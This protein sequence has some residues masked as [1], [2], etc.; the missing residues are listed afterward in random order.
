MPT[1]WVGK[2]SQTVFAVCAMHYTHVLIGWNHFCDVGKLACH[3]AK[4][5]KIKG[6]LPS[7][8]IKLK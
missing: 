3:N 6:G 5:K 1:S 8:A 7:N 4:K 2:T